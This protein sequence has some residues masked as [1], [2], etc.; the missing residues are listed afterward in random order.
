MRAAKVTVQAATTKQPKPGG[1]VTT[2]L[3]TAPP[4][5]EPY[6]QTSFLTQ[7]V[8]GFTYS[9]LL[10]FKAGV[11]EVSP[12]DFTMEPDLADAGVGEAGD[13]VQQRGLP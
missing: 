12:D 8:A 11:P 9:K 2:Q 10:R 7:W 4:S 5:L 13:G 3:P 1:S 6:T